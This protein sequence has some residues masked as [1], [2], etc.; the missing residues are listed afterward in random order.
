MWSIEIQ[1]VTEIKVTLTIRKALNVAKQLSLSIFVPANISIICAKTTYWDKK[2]VKF[3][4][5]RN[6]LV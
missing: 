2:T 5:H 6:F 4:C 1:A 3:E